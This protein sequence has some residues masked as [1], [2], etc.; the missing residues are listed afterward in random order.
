[1]SKRLLTVLCS[2]G[3]FTYTAIPIT[4][5]DGTEKYP[6]LADGTFVESI[7]HNTD[8]VRI[9][10]LPK[11]P[12]DREMSEFSMN[13]TSQDKKQLYF[14]TLSLIE[15]EEGL[16]PIFQ[17]RES[18]EMVF[19]TKEAAIAMKARGIARLRLYDYNRADYYD[20]ELWEADKDEY[21]YGSDNEHLTEKRKK[22]RR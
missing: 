20:I 4:V 18:S 9:T 1:M 22:H 8:Y 15:P 3:D 7:A 6:F 11:I 17:V 13:K 14:Y 2:V 10:G 19:V 21:K 5:Y 16:P 12:F